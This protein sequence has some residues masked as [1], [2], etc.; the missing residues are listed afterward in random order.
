M[1][2]LEPIILEGKHIQLVPLC[3]SDHDEMCRI[4]LDPDLWRLTT[5]EVL[6]PGVMLDYIR[7]A[8]ADQAAGTALPFVIR[9]KESGKLVGSSRYHNHNQTQRRIVI[10][11]T[12]IAREWQRTVVNT[13]TKYLMLRHAFEELKCVRVEF[14]VN[15]VNA[16]SRRALLRIGAIGEG[17]LRNYSIG[18]DDRPCDVMIFSIIDTEWPKVRLELEQKLENR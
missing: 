14:I 1:G 6:T 17:V 18:K 13:E 11:H 7:T 4:G 9:E 10:G 8:L 15:S 3:A 16:S 5:N 12:W 2:N